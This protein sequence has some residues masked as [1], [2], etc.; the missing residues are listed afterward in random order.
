MTQ[1]TSPN[2]SPQPKVGVGVAILKNNQVL[3]GLRKGKHEDGTWGLPGGSLEYNEELEDCAVR[4]T[5]EECG[6]TI[7]NIRRGPYVNAM[8][9][10][11]EKHF[12]V[13]LLIADWEYGEPTV[14][15][16]NRFSEWRWCDWDDMPKPLFYPLQLFVDSG[17]RP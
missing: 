7:K 15:E 2:I 6:V 10:A 1:T 3:L 8:H 11:N 14:T 16:P 5:K 9:Y 13:V 4:E 17:F 12:L